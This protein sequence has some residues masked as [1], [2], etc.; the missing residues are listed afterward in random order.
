MEKK[1]LFLFQVFFCCIVL[2][3]IYKQFY[4]IYN[5][6]FYNSILVC[7][8]NFVGYCII[9]VNSWTEFLQNQRSMLCFMIFN[10]QF[11]LYHV[12]L[13]A[14]SDG[15]VHYLQHL[16]CLGTQPGHQ[17]GVVVHLLG[18]WVLTPSSKLNTI[19]SQNNTLIPVYH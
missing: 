10:I 15:L 11:V 5:V 8:Y 4:N 12:L 6:N 18:G 7:K 2:A 16:L 19:K 14:V 3:Y 9:H 17:V 1:Y 13:L